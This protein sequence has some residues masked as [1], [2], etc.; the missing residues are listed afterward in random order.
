MVKTKICGNK[1]KN[2]VVIA[3][4]CDALGFIVGTPESARN[5]EPEIAARLGKETPTFTST[6]LVTT[7]VNPAKLRGLTETVKPDYLQLHSRLSPGR[8]EEIA[9]YLGEAPGIISLLAVT[10]S[11]E[12]PKRRARDL[13]DSP[14]EALLLD[15]R[16]DGQSGGTGRV[17]NWEISR[18]IRDEIYPFPVILAGG[19]TPDNVGAAIRKVR[20]Y[21]VDVATG[22]ERDGSKSEKKVGSFLEEVKQSE[23]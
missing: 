8:I 14:A 2:D 7:E 9:G 12:A 16:V 23:A 20:P 6:V 13:V 1:T 11:P 10:G 15:S 22:V 21:A 18:N 19:L 3:G 17:H 4:A 5:I